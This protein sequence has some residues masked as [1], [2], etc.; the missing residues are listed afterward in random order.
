MYIFGKK[1]YDQGL[2]HSCYDMNNINDKNDTNDISVTEGINTDN[3][4][5]NKH[6][7]TRSIN[8]AGN[9]DEIFYYQHSASRAMAYLSTDQTL[10]TTVF[11]KETSTARGTR[12]KVV[13]LVKEVINNG[14]EAD[15]LPIKKRDSN[16]TN[17]EMIDDIV[18][19][20]EREFK[21]SQP[22]YEN[23]DQ[24]DIGLVKEL[25]KM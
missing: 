2:Y 19:K 1:D 18:S 25:S 16:K 22:N 15:L 12:E 4:I 20:Y 14:F 9:S 10:F 8:S 3:N 24:F 13:L 6:T 17:V 23:V 21:T 5:I 7:K 11:G